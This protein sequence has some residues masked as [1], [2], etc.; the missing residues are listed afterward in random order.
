VR[1][2]DAATLKP[3]ADIPATGADGKPSK[4]VGLVD[5]PGR[6]FVFSLYDAGD[7]WIADMHDPSN[8]RLQRFRGTG[9]EP[10]DGLLSPDGRYYIA[11]LFG[12]DGL[13]LLDLWH[14]ERGVRA[15]LEGYGRGEERLPVYKMPHME[16]WAE[17]GDRFFL[18]AVGHHELLVV[19][20]QT[21]T[22]VGR[23]PVHGQPVFAEARP[24]GREVWVNF[25]L[26]DNDTV[27]V[28]DAETLAV[29]RTLKP[30]KGVLHME[31]TPRGPAGRLPAGS[32]A[33][34]DALPGDLRAPGGERA[35]RARGSRPAATRRRVE[36]RGRRAAPWPGRREHAGG[37]G[38]ARR[39]AGGGRGPGPAFPEL[40]HMSGKGGVWM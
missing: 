15:I 3:V 39:A 21:W 22:E 38:G 20:R 32:A 18:P 25:A 1:V 10:Y 34:P 33:F 6:R 14:P 28:I 8:P 35:R 9:K 11:G 16:G 26:P 13:R 37:S 2:F 17:A 24:D 36:P 12:E 30:G 40:G 7:I 5:A 31:F 27:Q 4:V 19:D 23:I 29:K